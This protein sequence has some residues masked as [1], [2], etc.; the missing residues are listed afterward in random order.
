MVK[1]L[2]CNTEDMGSIPGQAAKIPYAVELLLPRAAITEPVC[3]SYRAH[4]LQQ[5]I[6][7]N[8]RKVLLAAVKTP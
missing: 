5:K 6:P 1:N 7:H 3:H 4:V 2:S 8:A